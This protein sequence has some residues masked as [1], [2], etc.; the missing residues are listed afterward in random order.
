MKVEHPPLQLVQVGEEARPFAGGRVLTAKQVGEYLQI[1]AKK[2][3]ELPIPK[4]H[5]SEK[6]V[7]Y[8]ESD[9]QEYIRKHRSAE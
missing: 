1:P 4:V 6:R 9:V 7:R 3:Y 8:L 5:V 2:V